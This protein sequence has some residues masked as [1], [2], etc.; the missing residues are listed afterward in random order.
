MPKPRCV[1]LSL[2][3]K[4]ILIVR[5]ALAEASSTEA[6]FGPAFEAVAEK[7]GNALAV[8]QDPRGNS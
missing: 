8:L 6:Q 7:F 4:Q 2:T 5:Q 3:E 1:H